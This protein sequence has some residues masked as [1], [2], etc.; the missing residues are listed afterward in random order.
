MDFSTHFVCV[1]DGSLPGNEEEQKQ[2]FSEWTRFN[3]EEYYRY[4]HHITVPT[5]FVHVSNPELLL[6]C[7]SSSKLDQESQAFLDGLIVSLDAVMN[8]QECFVKLQRSPKDAIDKGELMIQ[9]IEWLR[10][11]LAGLLNKQTNLCD[12]DVLIALKAAVGRAL[13]A[14][15]G[16]HV[17]KNIFPLSNRI[18][19]DLVRFRKL[20]GDT[21]HK[22][23]IVVRKFVN[24]VSCSFFVFCF[25]FFC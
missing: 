2:L 15:S 16:S 18:V 17:L 22:L 19:S 25:F 8:G 23:Y 10:I 14:S 4:V 21:D 9:S 13:C 24:I 7:L 5:S 12:D 20:F 11:E 3:M 6:K 1:D